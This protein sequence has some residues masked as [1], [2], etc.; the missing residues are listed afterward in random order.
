MSNKKVIV[1]GGGAAGLMA[2]GTLS[3]DGLDVILAERND[4]PGRK[5]M[6][7]GKGRCN[8]TNNC[9]MINELVEN[10][11]TNGR[12]L[13]SA[14]S[15]FMPFDTMD[16]FEKRGVELKIERGERVFPVSDKAVDIVDALTSF[17]KDSG[18]K[19]VKARVTKLIIEDGQVKGVE[20]ESG[21]KLYGDAVIVATGGVSYPLT[22]STG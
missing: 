6:I 19:L 12:F 2:S 7:T 22:G 5:L 16:F 15:S 11:P 21:E 3:A 14:F 8:V 13:H 1:V 9:T 20:T 4:R 10:V 18:A 17:S